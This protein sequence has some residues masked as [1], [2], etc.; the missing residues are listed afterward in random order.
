MLHHVFWW[1]LTNV[2][3]VLNAS[4]NRVMNALMMEAVST[5]KT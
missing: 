1:K 5:S 3:E 2:S 4:I